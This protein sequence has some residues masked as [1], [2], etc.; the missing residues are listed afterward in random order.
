MPDLMIYGATG[1]TGALVADRAREDGGATPL[2]AG[3][4]ADRVADLAARRE[5]PGAAFGLDDPT[6]L[7]RQL[8][9]VRVVLNCAGPFSRTAAPLVAAC[10]DTGTHYV[11]ITGEIAVFEHLAAQ[12][13]AA[14]RAGL[15]LLPGAGFD[16]V[17]SDCL[18]AHLKRR[19]PRTRRL[20]LSISGLTR[21]SRGT[22]RT[23]LE[24]LGR[25]TPVRRGG[26]IVELA[27]PPRGRADF[28]AGPVETI[29]ISWGDVATAWHST[30]APE[31][32]VLFEASA[33]LRLVSRVP[34][35]LRPAL[36]SAPVR[37]L[38]TRLVDRTVHGPS[39]T[40]RRSGHA[41][42]LGEGWDAA[43]TRVAAL[44]ETPEPYALTACTALAI[45]RRVAAGAAPAGYH[46]PATAFGPDLALDVAGVR[47]TD[48]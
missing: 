9:D 14:R 32:D 26:E 17:P 41:R 3:R 25:G 37:G 36:R 20:R 35:P 8:E 42:L 7:R 28:G 38:L 29:G 33:P 19:Q 18:A 48:L 40:L 12:D 10:L 5:M 15:V 16:V 24:A 30:G 23:A 46:T 11:D 34:A 22:A 31:I 4:D 27:T 2:L 6:G 44:M 43:G 47:R 1:F 13:A 39:A 21:P 45:A